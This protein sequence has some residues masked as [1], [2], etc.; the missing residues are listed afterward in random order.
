MKSELT[1][2]I[3]MMLLIATAVLFLWLMTRNKN[4]QCKNCRFFTL[5]KE[6]KRLGN[7][8][9]FFDHHFF[10]EPACQGWKQ[11]QDNQEEEHRTRAGCIT[12]VP[13]SRHEPLL[14]C[15][16]SSP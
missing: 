11:K 6:S 2:I 3:F 1:F 12:A 15:P 16:E 7:C 9:R 4:K 14:R 13:I 8:T 5:R 10:W